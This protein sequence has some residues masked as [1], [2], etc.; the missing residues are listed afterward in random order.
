MPTVN[1][2]PAGVGKCDNCG[3][4]NVRTIGWSLT[5]RMQ[6]GYQGLGSVRLCVG[7]LRAGADDL[8]ALPPFMEELRARLRAAS[9]PFAA[10]AK[11]DELVALVE[12]LDAADAADDAAWAASEVGHRAN[13]RSR[14]TPGS[15]HPDSPPDRDEGV[16]WTKAPGET[17]PRSASDSSPLDEG[18]KQEPA[19]GTGTSGENGDGAPDPLLAFTRDRL[20]VI[21]VA[22]YGLQKPPENATKPQIVARIRAR[23]AELDGQRS[24]ADP[25]A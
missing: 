11:M 22:D 19:A 14:A 20:A 10:H 1:K 6:M 25:S 16:T 2:V 7:C 3:S 8:H 23:E 9:I 15:Q 5:E 18:E 12:K 13:M 24:G 4:E 17:F 21:A